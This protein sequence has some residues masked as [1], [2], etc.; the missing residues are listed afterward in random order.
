MTFNAYEMSA[1]LALAAYARPYVDLKAEQGRATILRLTY[2]NH[3]F[4]NRTYNR[5]IPLRIQ[6]E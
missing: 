6:N 2:T 4:L 5:T 3:A 1:P